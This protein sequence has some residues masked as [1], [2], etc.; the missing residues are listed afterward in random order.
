MLTYLDLVNRGLDFIGDDAARTSVRSIA[1]AAQAAMRSLI[2]L[3][4]WRYF[5]RS[6]LQPLHAI[7]TNT[8][9]VTY[10]HATRTVVW[11][12]ALPSWFGPGCGLIGASNNSFDVQEVVFGST[13]NFILAVGSN[14]G[15]D[16]TYAAAALSLVQFAFDLPV[17]FRAV[18]NC[19]LSNGAFLTMCNVSTGDMAT[20]RRRNFVTGTPRYYDLIGSTATMGRMAMN[21][22]PIPNETTSLSV[23]FKRKP[24]ALRI[25][26]YSVGTITA[27]AG[28]RTITGNGSA[29]NA[30]MVGSVLR[31]TDQAEAPTGYG[32]VNPYLEE[33]VIDS[34]TNATTLVA[35]TAPVYDYVKRKYVISDPVDVYDGS[36]NLLYRLLEREIRSV[37]RMA[38]TSEEQVNLQREIVTA[39]EADNAYSGGRDGFFAGQY[40][41]GLPMYLYRDNLS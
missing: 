23:H 6:Q 37:K 25:R 32:D 18:I 36:V 2:D 35:T 9:T 27:T 7:V 33:L 40:Q 21:V 5:R 20:L 34:V 11:D 39:L 19:G 31:L 26:D 4:D 30:S 14:P 1:D 28:T 16:Q 10:T 29:W 8:A 22:W 3:A 15:S 17:D 41:Q 24:R 13:T 38:A 12:S